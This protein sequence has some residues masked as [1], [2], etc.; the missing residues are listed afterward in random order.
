[1]KK[2]LIILFAIFS[3]FSTIQINS[4]VAGH[5]RGHWG[6]KGRTV[7]IENRIGDGF[8]PYIR[9]SDWGWGANSIYG[10]VYQIVDLWA[11]SWYNNTG[12]YCTPAYDRIVVCVDN[13]PNNPWG[14]ASAPG[15]NAQGHIQWCQIGLRS[16]ALYD[17]AAYDH[18]LGHCLGLAHGGTGVMNGSG[19]IDG[20]DLDAVYYAHN[21][22]PHQHA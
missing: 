8:L 14:Y 5:N 21:I 3:L 2:K 4:A 20:H 12:N 19:H 15:P 10:P 17:Q 1:M 9:N 22:G 6:P 7:Y 11:L 18:E 16:E 13:G